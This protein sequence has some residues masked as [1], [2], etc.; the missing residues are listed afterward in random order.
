MSL[1][2]TGRQ[3]TVLRVME[4]AITLMVEMQLQFE[5]C[6][7]G[8][9]R[10]SGGGAGS[11]KRGA[12]VRPSS[13]YVRLASV[14]MHAQPH[15]LFPFPSPQKAPDRTSQATRFSLGCLNGDA[16]KLT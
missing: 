6:A 7:L 12:L 9:A 11:A 4:P 13:P 15:P 5:R 10:H 1:V 16:L 2:E 3:E 8:E 14:L